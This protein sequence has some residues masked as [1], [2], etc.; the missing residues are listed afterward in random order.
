MTIK[1]LILDL[2]HVSFI[3]LSIHS[4]YLDFNSYSY[5]SLKYERSQQNSYFL[6]FIS[7][8]LFLVSIHEWHEVT[9]KMALSGLCF[10]CFV[11]ISVTPLPRK[12]FAISDT[13][14]MFFL[15]HRTFETDDGAT[16]ENNSR[17]AANIEF[18]LYMYV[19]ITV[20]VFGAISYL[21]FYDFLILRV[22]WYFFEAIK[23][24]KKY[25]LFLTM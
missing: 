15:T 3:C 24:A 19:Y 1:I 21:S 10:T 9:V 5:L 14:Y 8:A 22:L 25:N 11:A 20:C 6:S 2:S 13:F 18:I 7:C 12:Q 16:A 17:N 4:S 23:N